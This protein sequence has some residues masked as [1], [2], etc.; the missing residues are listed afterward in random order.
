MTFAPLRSRPFPG[1]AGAHVTPDET[2]RP[3]R[4]GQLR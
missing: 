1:T 3:K 2:V 4:N